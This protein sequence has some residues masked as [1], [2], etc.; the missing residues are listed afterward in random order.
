[1]PMK[2]LRLY[3]DTTIWNFSFAD[4]APTLRA[5]TIEFF[6]LVRAGRYVTHMSRTVADEVDDA[7]AKRK[8]E[9]LGLMKEI[10]PVFLENNEEVDRLGD[11][12]ISRK[13]L[14]PKSRDDAQHLAFATFYE[15]DALISWN[16]KH[17]ANIVKKD[18][19]TAV[20]V[21]EGYFHPLDLVTPLE[22]LG[23]EKD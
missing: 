10:E 1:M 8:Q 17:L 16:F 22:V 9:I 6:K 5:E 12:Y 23:D 3:L 19:M 14:P 4:D 7:P 21:S 15:M 11:L 20:N 18:R 2:R 13:V